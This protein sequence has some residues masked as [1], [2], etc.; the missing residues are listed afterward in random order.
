MGHIKRRLAYD[1]PTRRLGLPSHFLEM[2]ALSS[3]MLLHVWAPDPSRRVLCTPAQQVIHARLGA[4]LGGYPASVLQ[5]QVPIG[6]GGRLIL[7]PPLAFGSVTGKLELSW[8]VA[9]GVLH[10]VLPSEDA[11]MQPPLPELA[12]PAEGAPRIPPLP[13]VP[14]GLTLPGP[15]VMVPLGRIHGVDPDLVVTEYDRGLAEDIIQ[16]GFLR[17]LVLCGPP[18]YRVVDG[19]RRL[20]VARALRFDS[21]PALVFG[22]LARDDQARMRYLLEITSDRWNLARQLRVIAQLHLN[23]ADVRALAGLLRK[24]PRTLQRYLRVAQDHALIE[25]IE[26]GALSLMEAERRVAGASPHPEDSTD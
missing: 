21:I 6:S 20:E 12:A 9:E 22:P 13:P 26:R 8:E 16:Q 11:R 5:A 4:W 15:V 17:P 18:P 14:A 24:T 10:L 1:G 19:R 23:G 7:P 25:G 2:H 3:G